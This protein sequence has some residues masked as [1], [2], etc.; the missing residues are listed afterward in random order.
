MSYK[1]DLDFWDCFANGKPCHISE[2]H[3][4][5]SFCQAQVVA[6][7]TLEPEVPGMISSLA[8]FVSPS[9]DSRRAVVGYRQ[10]HVREVLVNRLGGLSLHRNSVVRLTDRPNMTIAV[11]CGHKTITQQQLGHFKVGNII[12]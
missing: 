7:L 8:T 4:T 11:Y 2:L 6:Q 3:K 12:L 9:T 1:T 5:R 10:K